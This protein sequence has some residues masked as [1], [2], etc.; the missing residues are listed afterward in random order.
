MHVHLEHGEDP[1]TLNLYVANGVT[2][3]RSMDGRPYILDWR[4]RVAE[5]ELIGPKIV[6]AGPI[7]D[8]DPPLRGDNLAMADA[9]AAQSAV[10]EQY[11]AGYDFI[12]IHTNLSPEAFRAAAATARELGMQAAGHVPRRVE[13]EDAIAW[14]N[15]IE[16]LADYRDALD[17]RPPAEARGW[18]WSKLLL[19]QPLGPAR[20]EALARDLAASETWTVPTLVETERRVGTIAQ[21]QAWRTLPEMAAIPSD[22]ID[23]WLE[24]VT[25][26]AARLDEE[27]WALVEAGQRN[28]LE[29]TAALHRGGAGILAGSDT[30]NPFLVPGA[31]LH[32]K[33]RLLVGAG[34]SP[35]H[36]LLAA[37]RNAARFLGQ[38]QD[39]GTVEAGRRADLVLLE[40]DPLTEIANTEQIAGVMLGGRWIPKDVLE[41]LKRSLLD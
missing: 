12:K 34:L 24:Q 1:D 29:L 27:D 7:L 40:A 41:R 20:M 2:T 35:G 21:V 25:G 8:G 28:R 38:E 31:S 4:R 16:H 32:R 9:P 36:A 37:T 15:S 17:A 23:F 3:V 19:A 13:L 5:G 11:R 10:Q 18:H 33:L 6:T 22:A 30:P 14:M 39:W 26:N